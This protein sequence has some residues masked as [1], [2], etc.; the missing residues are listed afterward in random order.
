MY[1]KA[2]MYE[3]MMDAMGY[4]ITLEGLKGSTGWE[5]F[6]VDEYV[7]YLQSGKL[8]PKDRWLTLTATDGENTTVVVMGVNTEGVYTQNFSI[9]NKLEYFNLFLQVTKSVFKKAISEKDRTEARKKASLARKRKRKAKATRLQKATEKLLDHAST[10]T[11]QTGSIVITKPKSDYDKLVRKHK[12]LQEEYDILLKA[13]VTS[14]R[15]LNKLNNVFILEKVLSNIKVDF[16][17]DNGIESFKFD[18]VKDFIN[19]WNKSS[20]R[21]KYMFK[22][23]IICTKF[24]IQLNDDFVTKNGLLSNTISL[25]YKDFKFS[26]N[27]NDYD[28][29]DDVLDEVGN[30]MLSLVKTI[31]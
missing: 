16:M 25:I 13:T 30:T 23:S 18:T 21:L 5:E 11:V 3:K 1:S 7:R 6:Y 20:V 19:Y 29:N 10:S 9:N 24:Y 2:V 15:P 8:D 22:D 27:H 12:K 14:I 28:E 31:M 4:V 17:L 26:I